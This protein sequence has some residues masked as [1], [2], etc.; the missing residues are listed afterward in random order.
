LN[1]DLFKRSYG[2]VF[3]LQKQDMAE[4]RQRISKERNYEERKKLENL[5]T[6]MVRQESG[7]RVGSRFLTGFRR[8]AIETE[9]QE[10]GRRTAK[11]QARMAQEAGRTG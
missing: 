4:L 7:D 9:G 5:L 3:D 11:D 10:S 6:G 2:F 8:T 1:E